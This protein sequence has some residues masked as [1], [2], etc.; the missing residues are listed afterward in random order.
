MRCAAAGC[1]GEAR[2][3]VER[4]LEHDVLRDVLLVARAAVARFV[5]ELNRGRRDLD[6]VVA[7]GERFGDAAIRFGRRRNERFFE[8]GV[9][10]L[11]PFGAQI[12][13]G[14]HR[15]DRDLAFRYRLDVAQQAA[16]A[17]LGE[18]DGYA[19]AT[20]TARAADAMDVGVGR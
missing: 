17:R 11:E 4:R 13:R 2:L 19:F 1:V 6:E 12:V 16:L 10:D 9:H 3:L 18:R 15:F 8:R 14:R 20:G 5:G 7:V